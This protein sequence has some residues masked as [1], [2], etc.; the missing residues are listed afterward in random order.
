[1]KKEIDQAAAKS[2]LHRVQ[3]AQAR[4]FQ[5]LADLEDE[6]G[7]ELNR[8]EEYEALSIEDLTSERIS[9]YPKAGAQ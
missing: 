8:T 1:M 4:F 3:R 7:I 6:L 2:A 5:A 9:I